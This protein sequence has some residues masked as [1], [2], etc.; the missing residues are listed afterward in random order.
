VT[1]TAAATPPTTRA[2]ERWATLGGAAYA[3][4][5]IVGVIVGSAGQPDTG[6]APEKLIRY[7]SDS[8]HRDRIFIGWI[9][10]VLGVFFFLW[11]LASLRQTLLRLEPGGFL[12]AVTSIGGI[13]YAAL[14]LVGWALQTA[15]KTMS[16][17]TYRHTVYPGLIHAA[18]DAGYVLHATGGIGAG[19]MMI[20]ASLVAL[21]AGTVA[22][23]LGWVGVAAGV[24][25][26]ASI[27][28]FP[29]ILIAVWLLVVSVGL[30]LRSGQGAQS[31]PR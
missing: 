13:V 28:F 11:F 5:F 19:T 31:A 6:S 14:T 24:I 16:D 15:I 20:G 2:L 26:L 25:A 8:G 1:T 30:F 23:W 22:S 10:V 27:A 4:L 17:D 3:I 7:Y 29:M 12:T 21:R 18:D 9:L